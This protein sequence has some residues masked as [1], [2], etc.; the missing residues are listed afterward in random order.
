VDGRSIIPAPSFHKVRRISVDLSFWSSHVE[1][2]HDNNSLSLFCAVQQTP[3]PADFVPARI[4]LGY[5][6]LNGLPGVLT[7]IKNTP[8]LT[9][10]R[11]VSADPKT[12]PAKLQKRGGA[13]KKLT[14]FIAATLGL[15]RA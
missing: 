7:G 4:R 8:P 15:P 5:H 2:H 13:D 3:T 12:D 1:F 10:A 14:G 9:S 6:P 11:P